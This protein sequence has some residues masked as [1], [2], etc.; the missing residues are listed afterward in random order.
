M[1]VWLF[2]AAAVWCAYVEA[3]RAVSLTATQ[4]DNRTAVLI[5]GQLRSANLSWSSGDLRE[6]PA[7]HFFGSSDPPT[8]A[9]CIIEWIFKPLAKMTSGVD[10][11]MYVSAKPEPTAADVKW[12]GQ[13]ATFVPVAGSGNHGVEACK[14]FSKASLFHASTKNHRFF[15]LVEPEFQLMNTFVREF[16]MWKYRHYNY[17][18]EKMNE[19]AL[20]QYY[21]HYRAN[22][23]AKQFAVSQNHEYMYKVR[24]RPDTP[25]SRPL[26]SLSRFDF[27]KGVAGKPCKHTIYYPNAKVGG[28]ADHFNIGRA[29]HMDALLDRYVDFT[30]T[31]F[32]QAA[33]FD[34]E[35]W[36]LEDHLASVLL[37]KH[38]ICLQWLDALWV[39]VIRPAHNHED[40]PIEPRP[41]DWQEL[42][43]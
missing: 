1:I 18:N 23:A 41:Y 37:T 13:A 26:P 29:T 14:I 10:V 31:L 42:S 24:L 38:Q 36:D 43:T 21:G 19:Q 33:H 25:P 4:W 40:W 39:V 15:C 5:S 12:D 20:Q 11:F 30:T 16:D 6:T 34:K 2:G 17:R 35:Y 7:F 3:V 8:P 27:D 32:K 28:H 22:E 9:D